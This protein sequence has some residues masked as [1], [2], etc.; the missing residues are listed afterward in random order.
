[1]TQIGSLFSLF[2]YS[3]VKAFAYVSEASEMA[4]DTWTQ[5][6][7]RVEAIE[8]LIL[9]SMEKSETLEKSIQRFLKDDFLCQFLV[10]FMF[11]KTL[12]HKHV[13][14]TESHHFPSMYP[15]LPADMELGITEIVAPLQELVSL[16]NVGRFYHF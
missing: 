9:E 16:V 15:S 8:S 3:P 14:F 5:C 6:I 13:G 1:M 7:A 10:R 2:L 4:A 12:L 11:C